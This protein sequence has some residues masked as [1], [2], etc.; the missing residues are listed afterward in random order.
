MDRNGSKP[1]R[2]MKTVHLQDIYTQY[3]KIDL[4]QPFINEKNVFNQVSLISVSCIG[5]QLET[6]QDQIV[7]DKIKRA[8]QGNE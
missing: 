1:M 5:Q 3:I 7:R 2:E 4:H 6:F 8:F